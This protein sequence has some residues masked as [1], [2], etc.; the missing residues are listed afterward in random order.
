MIGLVFVAV[1]L[2]L[3]WGVV[4]ALELPLA[5]AVIPTVTGVVAVLLVVLVRWLQ[6]RK[7]AQQLEG[8][9][10]S[11]AAE[12]EDAVRPD[13]KPEVKA[14]RAEFNKALASLKTARGTK[15]GASAL[16]VLPWYMIIGPPGGGKSTAL[17]NSG[18]QFPYLSKR[19]GGVKGVGGTRNCEWWFTKDAIVLDT[20]GRY[21]VEE[22]DH[23]EWL[24]F[25][26][27][28]IKSRP[29]KPINGLIV[30]ISVTE[31]MG[32][33]E[34]AAERGTLLRERV[35]EV[36]AKVRMNVP[37]YVLF[38]KC[39]LVSGFVEMFGDLG[40]T[41]RGQVWGFTEPLAGLSE[42]ATAIFQQRMDG[43]L[44]TLERRALVRLQKNRR[45]G[46]RERIW[47]FPREFAALQPNLSEFVGALFAE[48]QMSD[49]PPMRGVYFTS[50]TQEGKPFDRMMR[51]MAEAFGVGGSAGEEAGATEARSYFLKDLFSNVVFPDHDIAVASTAE[52]RRQ[53]R[54]RLWGV[55]GAVGL[56]LC[57]SILPGL[58]FQRNL[59]LVRETQDALV[60]SKAVL[61]SADLAAAVE[62]LERL[63]AQVE[64]LKGYHDDGA[65]IGMRLGMYVGGDLFE[66]TGASYVELTKRLLI[67]R[68]LDADADELRDFAGQPELTQATAEVAEAIEKLKLHLLLTT[69]K[70]EDEPEIG[71]E[72]IDWVTQRIVTRWVSAGELQNEEAQALALGDLQLYLQLL[73][74]DRGF[75]YPR[76]QALLKSTRHAMA[77]V[78]VAQLTLSKVISDPAFDDLSVSLGSQIGTASRY[79]KGDKVV[80]GA[81]TKEA[82]EGRVRGMLGSAKDDSDAWVLGLSQSSSAAELKVEYFNLY[83]AEWKQFIE[84]LRVELPKG[85]DEAMAMLEELTRVR[86]FTKLFAT[87]AL[88]TKLSADSE[89]VGGLK[90]GV[91]KGLG[92]RLGKLGGAIGG[93]ADAGVQ[94]LNRDPAATAA[95]ELENAFKGLVK[96][97]FSPPPAEGQ[98]PVP[99]PLLL[100][101]EDLEKLRDA[102]RNAIENPRESAQLMTSLSS[103]RV[104]VKSSVDQQEPG[105]RPTIERFV[106]PPIS[107]LTKTTRAAA[108]EEGSNEWCSQVAIPFAARIGGKYPFRKGGKDVSLDDTAEFYRPG[109]L[110]D[111]FYEAVLMRDVQRSGDR[112]EFVRSMGDAPPYSAGLL[113]FLHR[114]KEIQSALFP[115]QSAEPRVDF[116]IHIRPAKNV[117]STTLTIDGETTEYRNGQEEWRPM[118]WPGPQK[119]AGA[120]VRV[121]SK[122]GQGDVLEFPGDWGLFRLLESGTMS[123]WPGE[124]GFAV[125]WDAPTLETQLTIDFRPARTDNPLHKD[126]EGSGGA[127][128]AVLRGPFVA[129]PPSIGL[130]TPPCRKP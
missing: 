117:A 87:I 66:L 30:A 6:A 74:E 2:A 11:Q 43:L 55:L 65:P 71:E 99:T 35:D 26:S 59:E 121:K 90:A 54:L 92:A 18:L 126:T 130:S 108:A 14:M 48:N 58:S 93:L 44:Q 114:A 3:I 106:W 69:P 34:E 56:A 28:V 72:L 61:A 12:H 89:G 84:S 119:G 77:K 101:M 118:R 122:Q 129:P 96:F 41:E 47:Q 107:W 62:K 123:S 125:T 67:T 20:A 86:P 128:L 27:T 127:L 17:R 104:K 124:R 111:A 110:V 120:S 38:T 75:F 1:L 113:Q 21:A 22:D 45:I 19:G 40:R 8:S 115:P 76:D 42:G 53:K 68:V 23:E 51:S 5:I 9:I 29:R 73:A 103:V 16:A 82:W 95:K 32:S 39:D 98:P 24:S 70:A 109:G 33:E 97:G 100:Y 36:L 81:F 85:N 94:A 25:L 31:L 102:L 57:F 37:L 4:V 7:A 91:K 13:M 80:R 46:A 88:N 15:G 63:R 10:K 49:T 60:K 78:P 83:I 112:F 105:W 64:K 50:G 52:T 116:L 79:I